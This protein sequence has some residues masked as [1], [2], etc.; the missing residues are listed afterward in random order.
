[1]M[2]D[3]IQIKVF[4][5][6]SV[7]AV[8]YVPVFQRWIREHALDELLIDVVDYSHVFHGPEVAL[9]GH[10]ADYVLDRGGGR[11]GLLYAKKRGSVEEGNPFQAALRRATRACELLE[12]ESAVPPIAFHTRE[13][14]IR[15]ADRLNAPNTDDTFR[16]VEP[17]VRD[18]LAQA[19]GNA[20]ITLDRTGSPR[21]LFTI[22]AHVN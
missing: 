4:A 21:D 15:I 7:N 12:S 14:Q 2:S 10:Q 17:L 19:Y 16:R 11:F 8:D 18:A 13:L 5:A 3:R 6:G 20:P 9:I 22:R 1:M